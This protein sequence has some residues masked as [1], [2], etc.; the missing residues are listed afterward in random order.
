MCV[1]RA[2]I[3]HSSLAELILH[4]YGFT[5]EACDMSASCYTVNVETL[6]SFTRDEP[7]SKTGLWSGNDSL[8]L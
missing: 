7:S 1:D 6:A 2:V 3:D 4:W 5:I 8:H